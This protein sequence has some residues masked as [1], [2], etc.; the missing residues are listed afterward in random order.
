M[1]C[2]SQPTTST[3]KEVQTSQAADKLFIIDCLLPGQMRRLGANAMYMTGRR[4]IKT[5]ASECEIRGGEYVAFDRADLKTSL[6]IWLPQ[7]IKGDAKAQAYVGEMYE[8]GL[9]VPPNYQIAKKWYE[10]SAKQNNTTAQLN[11]GYLYEKGFGVQ[12]NL[13]LAMQWYEKASGLENIDIPYSATLSTPVDKDEAS[14]E[15]KL[16][17]SE[18]NNSRLETV[19]TK[20][21]L[22]ESKQQLIQ[23]QITLD[24]LHTT[25]FNDKSLLKQAQDNQ[26]LALVSSL[27][28]SI[29]KNQSHIKKQKTEL[30]NQQILYSK[31]LAQ[32]NNKLANTQK[33]AQQLSIEL[34]K[35]KS[36]IDSSQS[37]LLQT[38]SLLAKT[39]ANLIALQRQSQEKLNA[40]NNDKNQVIQE[41]T[42]K[43]SKTQNELKLTQQ[44]LIQ[45][46]QDKLKQEILLTQLGQDKQEFSNQIKLL[47]EQLN[48]SNTSKTQAQR[49]NSE[50]SSVK[51][52]AANSQQQVITLE[53][54]LINTKQQLKLLNQSTQLALASALADTSNSQ[55]EIQQQQKKLLNAEQRIK[56]YENKWLQQQKLTQQLLTEKNRYQA[57]LKQLNTRVNAS[58]I[59]SKLTIEI[60]D[61]PFTLV[62]GLKLAQNKPMVKLRS[63]VKEREVFG[64]VSSSSGLLSLLVNDQKTNIDSQGL[65]K[66]NIRLV[67]NETHV[68]IV[69]I[70]K[71]G[72][73]AKLDFVFSLND[74]K[75]SA[76][77]SKTLSQSANQENLWKSLDFGHY[78]AL[79]I[80][81]NDYQ[82]I[83]SLDTPINDAI[84]VEKV[85][86]EKYAFDSITLLKNASRYQIL[87][88]L[89]KLRANLTEDDNLLIYY[90][91]HGELDKANMRGHWLP[92]DADADNTAN[93]IST[94]AITDILNAMSAKHVLIVSDSCYSGAMT[95]SSLARIDAG[96]SRS[97]KQAWLKAMLKTRSRTVLTSGGL[98]PVLDGGG[99]N[100]SVFAKAL[101]DALR[102]N[103]QLLEG[104]DLYRQVSGGIIKVASKYGIEQVP[105]YAPIRH[106]GHESGEFFLIPK[107]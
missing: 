44:A 29:T 10:K 47:K 53:E 55:Q 13:A 36:P 95:R 1:A 5:T 6:K 61:P 103:T 18:L 43:Q 21:L 12:K 38:E 4:P 60:I 106:A 25:L 104:Q 34:F 102:D 72:K 17:N 26:N 93:W 16:L 105:E 30:A 22:T 96:V 107:Q 31:N 11:L 27:Q 79:I 63:V 69:A 67:Q 32:L 82:K 80:G 83:T 14:S 46:Q 9:G 98:K 77:Q 92:I 40:I 94:V 71:S 78:H 99:G 23:Q 68:N 8:K 52:A 73:R 24:T 89:N 64:K 86:K 70:D 45:Q 35:N 74:A 62:R 87:S 56:N 91:G 54:Q 100:H 101:I 7:A 85:L 3:E 50:L 81:N 97:K 19:Q 39:E 42:T 28:I 75:E 33:R 76:A 41:A 20:K 66:S 65:F 51:I 57:E 58:S 49:L 88:A 37:H 59:S 90:A 15:I 48:N 2:S 84:A